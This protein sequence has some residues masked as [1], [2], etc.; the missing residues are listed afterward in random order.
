MNKKNIIEQYLDLYAEP[1][2]KSICSIGY[3]FQ[4]VLI[5]PAINE[6]ETLLETLKSIS[7]KN[8]L[9]IIVVNANVES[10][11]ETLETNQ[12]FLREIRKKHFEIWRSKSSQGIS[13]HQMENC[14]I[15]LIDKSSGSLKIPI[16]TGV[17]HARK[18][19]ADIALALIHKKNIHSEWIHSTDADVILPSDYFQRTK[20][21]TQ[22]T[23]SAIY[24]Y[25]HINEG[26]CIKQNQATLLY[27]IALRHYVIGLKSA[28]SPYAF[29]TIG[30]TIS[31][32]AQS[33]AMVRG[34]PKKPAG[35]DFYM[36]NKLAKIGRIENLKGNPIIL[37]GRISDRSPFGTGKSIKKISD[38][39]SPIDEYLFYHPEIFSILS[40][41]VSKL[42]ELTK[43][44]NQDEFEAAIR[45]NSP[46]KELYFGLKKMG[47][48]DAINSIIKTNNA[49]SLTKQLHTWFDGFRTL[50]LIHHLRE[51]IYPS[52][53][54]SELLKIP[55]YN[56]FSIEAN[57]ITDDLDRIKQYVTNLES[58]L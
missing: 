22:N 36:L 31:F 24:P 55:P 35:E 9:A 4:N 40:F 46:N 28:H 7:E 49:S 53:N 2:A 42:F 5:I 19:A 27:D 30:S 41:W 32:R 52:I 56:H 20:K 45:E 1:E 58:N 39:S 16:K 51:T 34:F 14:S 47:A 37:S 8:V 38:F 3:Y 57:T 10:N 54:L 18:I 43:H 11:K 12:K 23:V 17:G 13:L 33:Y 44:F 29:H 6:F 21:L 48:F 15:M 50:K 26:D 25:E